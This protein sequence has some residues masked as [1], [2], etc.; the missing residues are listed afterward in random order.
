M[1]LL[2]NWINGSQRYIM[3]IHP[4]YHVIGMRRMVYDKK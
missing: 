1:E 4:Y 2:N 3:V